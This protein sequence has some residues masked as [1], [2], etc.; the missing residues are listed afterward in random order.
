LRLHG[1]R[2]SGRCSSRWSGGRG[3]FD[4]SAQFV[5][6]LDNTSRRILRAD[7]SD[8]PWVVALGRHVAT[9]VGTRTLHRR[10]FLGSLALLHT[11]VIAMSC[12]GQSQQLACTRADREE[13]ETYTPR[14]WDGMWGVGCGMLSSFATNRKCDP[15]GPAMASSGVS[16]MGGKSTAASGWQAPKSTKG[17]K[18]CGELRRSEKDYRKPCQTSRVIVPFV[19]FCGLYLRAKLK[20]LRGRRSTYLYENLPLIEADCWSAVRAGF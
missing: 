8:S 15:L 4:T 19:G 13:E 3:A 11:M 5:L 16:R 10:L 17:R 7:I 14:C 6:T 1:E 18:T 20:E 12:Q 9:M 2:T